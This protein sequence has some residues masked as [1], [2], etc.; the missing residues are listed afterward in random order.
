MRGPR[1]RWDR[2]RRTFPRRGSSSRGRRRRRRASSGEDGEARRWSAASRTVLDSEV[3]NLDP[4]H[5]YSRTGSR[6]VKPPRRAGSR[7]VRDGAS[8]LPPAD[9]RGGRDVGA[10]CTCRDDAPRFRSLP[11]SFITRTIWLSQTILYSHLRT[12]TI[13]LTP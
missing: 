13:R 12:P 9:S 1:V 6:D 4:P 11:Q 10:T 8:T 2:A 3:Y 5:C 7:P